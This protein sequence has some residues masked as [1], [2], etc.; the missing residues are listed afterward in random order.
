MPRYCS[1]AA[2]SG[3]AKTIISELQPLSMKMPGNPTLHLNLGRAYMTA[4]DPP[5]LDQARIQFLEALKIE[6]RYI[7]ARL[8]LGE[9][10]LARGENPQAV[11]SAGGSD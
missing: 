8:A 3:R 9:L 11:Q 5:S 6:P 2:I 1:I 7:P 10:Q 4:G